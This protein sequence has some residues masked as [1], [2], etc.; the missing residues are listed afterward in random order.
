[1][2][3]KVFISSTKVDL[4]RHRDAVKEALIKN[5]YFPVEMDDF[6]ARDVDP[7]TGC[8]RLVAESQLFLGIYAWRYGYVPPGRERSITAEELEQARRLGKP[9]FCF[10]VD[11]SYAWP[12]APDVPDE[13]PEPRER[14]EALKASLRSERMLASFTTPEQLALEVVTALR[15]WELAR[16]PAPERRQLLDLLD[17][18]E[19]YWVKSVLQRSVPET[20]LLIRD[21]EERESDVAQPWAT[22]LWADRGEATLMPPRTPLD[23][24]VERGRRLLI[25]GEG[26]YGKTTDL[27]QLA[28]G[29][30]ELAR[31]D[32]EQPVPVVLKL[33][34]WGWQSRRL[35]SWM[36]R[37]VHEHHKLD[38]ALVRGWIDDDR[39]L[40]LLDGLDEVEPGY[41][42]A[43]AHAINEFLA[44]H[45]ACSLAVSCRSDVNDELAE[46]LDLR[47]AYALRPL[48][49]AALD[50]YLA[51]SGPGAEPLRTA[52]QEQGW[53]ELARI[54]LLLVMMDRALR[55][56]GAT[57]LGAT[58][59]QPPDELTS[60]RRRVLEAYVRAMLEQPAR[61]LRFPAARSRRALAW[62]ARQMSAHR[63][64]LLQLG[65]L[66][67]SWLRGGPS[68][69]VYAVASRALG[70]AL[71][72]LPVALLPMDFLP[73]LQQAAFLALVGLAAGA[74]A[75]LLDGWRLRHTWATPA[76]AATAAVVAAD[77]AGSAAATESLPHRPAARALAIGGAA[78]LCFNLFG[79][80][81]LHR[82]GELNWRS[83]LIFG[84]RYGLLF[85][86]LLGLVFGLRRGRRERGD[87]EIAA[88]LMRTPWSWSKSRQ[89]A[90][91]PLALM[92][93]WWLVD[94][95]EAALRV[96][97]EFDGL[98]L[99]LLALVASILGG[100]IGGLMG[101]AEEEPRGPRRRRPGL[102]Q[103]L[104]GTVRAAWLPLLG[105][106]ALL[107]PLM[108]VLMLTGVSF[109]G[110]AWLV[111]ASAAVTLAWW[112]ALALRGLDLVQHL[113]LR[114]LLWAA[115]TFP[116]RWGRFLDQ[117][118]DCNLMHR[119]G[120][121]WE[122]IH[123]WL[124]A[125]L[126]AA[127]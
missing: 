53:R 54:P 63:L 17:K 75:G 60:G 88:G 19:R 36:V 37:E 58:P 51:A 93:L 7:V 94:R 33:G 57:A 32:P 3:Q 92:A 50:S 41:R 2:V 4:P 31:D 81:L 6:G 122:F 28:A 22:P 10:L 86:A 127:A 49:A 87:T 48:S 125:E 109:P 76:T 110:D 124:L 96:Y 91:W 83:D 66:Q 62:L 11:E 1:M 123:P 43:C 35:D 69:W 71:L 9:R 29:L 118:V 15:R 121:G 112:S 97:S 21:R 16:T 42:E 70:G 84:L 72:M 126:A 99:A 103:A 116:L 26:G 85:G 25:L 73:L 30:V 111:P 80:L 14:L 59:S 95:L 74:V 67:P 79:G 104:A 64:A 108:L 38:P 89:G 20:G 23:L 12:A 101:D 77:A 46:R 44:R 18:V 98:F 68:V 107:W 5:G 8:L 120:P 114:L 47:D 115:G 113:T 117:A 24:F 56:A 13:G 119:V 61:Q 90:A 106:A 45:S 102:R 55:G 105:A 34:S 27:L 65:E 40:P 82:A 78:M 39:L 100:L 52:L